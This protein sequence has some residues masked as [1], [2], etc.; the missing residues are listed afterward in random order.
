MGKHVAMGWRIHQGGAGKERQKVLSQCKINKIHCLLLI[1]V[2]LGPVIFIRV[3]LRF[4]I[5]M[6]ER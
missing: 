3:S 5:W 2:M 1:T 4:C 6:K